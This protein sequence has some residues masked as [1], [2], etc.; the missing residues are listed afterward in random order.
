MLRNLIIFG[1]LILTISINGQNAQIITNR[2]DSIK[3]FYFSE[4]YNEYDFLNGREYKPYYNP[5]SSSPLLESTMG[6]GTI[7]SNGVAFENLTL[8]YDRNQ[9][10][11]IVMPDKFISENIYVTLNKAKVD[12]FSIKYNDKLYHLINH[13][14]DDAL[15][16][17]YYEIPYRGKNELYIKYY[18]SNLYNNG[19]LTYYPKTKRYLLKDDLCFQ[20]KKKKD[21]FVIFSEHKKKIRKKLRSF[22]KPFKQLTNY[23]ISQ[24]LQFAES[25]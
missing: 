17:G 4:T 11:L 23:Q 8:L 20:I 12:S 21:L 7:F 10:E 13:S 15:P 25:L 16:N 3:N 18:T 6:V 1:F 19:V 9:D 5:S 14:S 22:H 2:V 24:V